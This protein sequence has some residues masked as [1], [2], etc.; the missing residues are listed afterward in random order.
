MIRW[1]STTYL[2][3]ALEFSRALTRAWEILEYSGAR[4]V[5]KPS[6]P[7]FQLQSLAHRLRPSPRRLSRSPHRRAMHRLSNAASSSAVRRS[8]AK[9]AKPV[10]KR[11]AHKEI[12][13]SNEGRASILKGVDVLANAVSVTLGPKGELFVLTHA[14]S[15]RL[16]RL[17]RSQRHHRATLWRSQDH[18]RSVFSKSPVLSSDHTF[19]FINAVAHVCTCAPCAHKFQ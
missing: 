15:T 1:V 12:K 4:R 13:F 17:P 5:H 18:K 10:L 8:A 3:E 19:C 16:T 2:G 7:K 6:S 11:G 9:A 14:T